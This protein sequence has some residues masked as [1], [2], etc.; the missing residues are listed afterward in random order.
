MV[1]EASMKI[2][3]LAIATKLGITDRI[4]ILSHQGKSDL[5]ASFPRKLRAWTQHETVR[6]VVCRD[7]DGADCKKLKARLVESVGDQSKHEFKLRIVMNELEAWYLGDL[8]ALEESQLI[9]EGFA[10]KLARRGKYREPERLNNAKQEFLKL[11]NTKGQTRIAEAVAP[12]LS[13]QNNTSPSFHQ[14]VNALKWAAN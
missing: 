12:N 7:N 8:K 13:I 1:E 14:F 9:K 4:T 6:F 5:E 11:V 3:A 10:E 2:V